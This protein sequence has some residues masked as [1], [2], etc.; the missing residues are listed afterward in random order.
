MMSLREI[1]NSKTDD[2]L[3][4]TRKFSVRLNEVYHELLAQ[5]ALAEGRSKSEVFKRA[6]ESYVVG[7]RR[8]QLKI[9]DELDG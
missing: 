2:E 7:I 5:A 9:A 3:R 4:G 6:I 1:R 8:G